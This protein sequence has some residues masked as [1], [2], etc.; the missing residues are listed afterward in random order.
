[1]I[2][3]NGEYRNHLGWLNKKRK[4]LQNTMI[5]HK[6]VR[7]ADKDN[8]EN[9]IWKDWFFQPVAGSGATVLPDFGALT[10]SGFNPIV[11]VTDNKVI[12]PSVG[13]ITIT[14]FA[15]LINIPANINVGVGTLS[16]VGFSPIVSISGGG[17][18]GNPVT[19]N[20][21]HIAVRKS[22]GPFGWKT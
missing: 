6:T 1:M 16:L 17:S 8:T 2:S 3:G 20:R 10:L 5:L 12:L 18:G 21:R 15:P 13:A 19:S 4:P 7:W 11:A 22:F 9:T 14:G